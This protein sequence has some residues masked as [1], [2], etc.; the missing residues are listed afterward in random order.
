MQGKTVAVLENRLGKQLADLIAKRGARALHAPA[1]SEVPD[2]D[3]A[4]VERLIADL[5]SHAPQVA[6]FQTGVGT[7]ALF[8]ATDGLGVTPR[9]LNILARATVVVRGPKPT[10]ALRSRGVR[11]DL[12]AQEPFTTAEV[13]QA[14][15]GVDLTGA[16]V[17]VQRY[18]VTNVELEQALRH[19]GSN[20][21]EIPTYRW[22][23]PA[24]TEPLLGLIDAL[25]AG[26]VDAVVFTNAA[27]VHNFFAIAE[28]DHRTA[29]LK[30]ALDR[31]LVAS[32]GPVCSDALRKFGLKIGLEPHPPKLGP[33]VSSLDEALSR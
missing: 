7:H 27:Q 9:L 33:L 2:V 12:A 1:L 19:R 6:I 13:L 30:A 28:R 14:L 18:G 29:S 25:E 11:V 26:K 8:N 5:Q 24:D 4:F 3:P 20:V 10:A 22:A 15:Q 16:R 17:V 32:I 23:L 21:I 31:T